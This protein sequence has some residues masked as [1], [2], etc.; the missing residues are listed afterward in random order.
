MIFLSDGECSVSDAA[1]QD[2]CRSA[3]RLGYLYMSLSVQ[4]HH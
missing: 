4:I 2:L 1:I 3:I